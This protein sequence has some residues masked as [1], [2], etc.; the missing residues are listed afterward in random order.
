MSISS[1]DP[2]RPGAG[3]PETVH[4]PPPT[5]QLC[6]SYVS[7]GPGALGSGLLPQCWGALSRGQIA[8]KWWSQ[9]SFLLHTFLP[10]LPT[11]ANIAKSAECSPLKLKYED[12]SLMMEW[13]LLWEFDN[14][15]GFL[16]SKAFIVTPGKSKCSSHC[17]YS[18]RMNKFYS[19]P[20][21]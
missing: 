5:G 1:W 21:C 12:P 15:H 4:W 20:L 3:L 10:D 7:I 9:S 14:D 18:Q 6:L 11:A 2:K 8:L 16:Q 13:T 17:I 19:Y